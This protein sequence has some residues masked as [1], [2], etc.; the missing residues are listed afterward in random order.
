MSLKTT[1]EACKRLN[2]GSLNLPDQD[3]LFKHLDEYIRALR[4]QGRLGKDA[5]PH[6]VLSHGFMQ[7][8]WF[9]GK[10]FPCLRWRNERLESLTR[11]EFG[12]FFYDRFFLQI[13]ELPSL[14]DMSEQEKRELKE[15]GWKTYL[16][17]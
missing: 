10:M 9:V 3:T 13:A 4:E 5:I 17:D 2:E 12:R 11:D 1:Q 14:Q 7:W 6:V 16:E 8:G 15:L